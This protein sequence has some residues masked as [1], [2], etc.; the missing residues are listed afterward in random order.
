MTDLTNSAQLQLSPEIL[1]QIADHLVSAKS[2]LSIAHPFADGDAIGS[3]LAMHHFCKALG[4]K[5]VFLNFD[6]IP[7]SLTWLPGLDEQ[8]STVSGRDKFDLMFLME[9][10][11]RSRMG[12]RMRFLDFAKIPIHIDHHP[13]VIGLGK[14]NYIDPLVSSTCELLYEIFKLTGESIPLEALICIY[15]GIVTDTGNFRFMNSTPR[16]HEIAG[17]IIARGIDIAEIF[18]KIYESNP[19]SKVLLHGLVMSRTKMIPGFPVSYSW[20]KQEDFANQGATET[21]SDGVIN[22]LCAISNVEVAAFF[23]EIDNGEIKIS[24][25]SIGKI[26]VQEVCKVFGGGGHKQAAGAKLAGEL[27]RV[28]QRTLE[29]IKMEC[30]AQGLDS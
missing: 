11:D 20:L 23:R 30:T 1:P 16:S 28:I 13:E 14:I 7:N 27:D 19:V 24:L 15:V 12:E 26:N 6:P 8:T 10:T 29:E 2:V 5:S 25:R 9:T 17:E 22:Q 18:R 4:K 3:Q 21:D